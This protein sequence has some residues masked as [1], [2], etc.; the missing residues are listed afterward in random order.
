MIKLFLKFYLVLAI[1]LI[2]LFIPP[3]NPILKLASYWLE[4]ITT[5]E[6]KPVFHLLELE[7]QDVEESKTGLSFVHGFCGYGSG[8]QRDR[9]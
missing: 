9:L 1:P 4:E 7:L 6:Y 8:W 2:F 3:L 5:K